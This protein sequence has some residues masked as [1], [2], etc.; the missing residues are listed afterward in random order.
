MCFLKR[1]HLKSNWGKSAANRLQAENS[2][3]ILWLFG[4]SWSNPDFS[5]PYTCWR[6]TCIFSPH[7]LIENVIYPAFRNTKHIFNSYSHKYSMNL[8]T[9][10]NSHFCEPSSIGHVATQRF[11]KMQQ[12]AT[13][14]EYLAAFKPHQTFIASVSVCQVCVVLCWVQ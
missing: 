5:C 10:V 11:K 6:C 4:L 3:G 9:S 13:F 12:W 7:Y 2:L 8:G 14:F 1:D